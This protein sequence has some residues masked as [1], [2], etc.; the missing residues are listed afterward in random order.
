MNRSRFW[1]KLWA[2]LAVAAAVATAAPSRAGQSP[3]RPQDQPPKNYEGVSFFGAT[4]ASAPAD[5]A[6]QARYAQAR[7][8]FESA[9]T[10]EHYV[11]LGRRT[12]YL[13][14]YREAIGIYTE[15]LKKFPDSYQLYRH[16]G[17]RYISIR[18]FGRAIADFEKAALLVTGKPIEVEPDGAP[19]KAGI[20]VSNTQFNIYYHLGLAHFLTRDFVKAEAAYRECLKWSKNDDSVVAV[21]DWLYMTLRRTGQTAAAAAA[22]APIRR[23][24][25][26]IENGAYLD[27]LLM[28]KGVIPEEEFARS[29]P[30]ENVSE[31]A[32]RAYGMGLVHLWRGD[33]ARARALFDELATSGSWASFATIAAEVE[34]ADLVR[35]EPDRSS[36]ASTLKA[37]TLSWNTYD[38]DLASKLFTTQPPPTYFSSEKPGRI[39]GV[40]MLQ[41]HHKGFGFVPGGKLADNR[42]WLEEVAIQEDGKTAFVTAY[43]FFDRDVA[44][45][46]PVQRGPVTFVLLRTA[47]GWRFA[48]AHFANDP[49]R[50]T[51]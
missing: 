50:S 49:P 26:L 46:G 4:L 45:I 17:H 22:L 1:S 15:G 16:R 6:A 35:A 12:A 44:A 37:W 36:V 19:N 18:Q 33:R 24:L 7:R 14:R 5:T 8:D 43:W 48:H 13:G 40:D 41:A 9:Q 11:W 10:E 30:G 38:L 31:Q 51:S 28:F 25:T 47:D 42:L 21:T 27:R 32:V 29:K 3:S 39:A 34:L 23:D 20:P 2:T